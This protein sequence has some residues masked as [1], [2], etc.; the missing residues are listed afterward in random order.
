MFGGYLGYADLQVIT[1]LKIW[2]NV[3]NL[4]EIH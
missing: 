3:Q 4:T 1:I 2:G